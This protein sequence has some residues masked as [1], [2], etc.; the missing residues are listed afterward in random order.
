MSEV[1]PVYTDQRIR[2]IS[3]GGVSPGVI[4]DYSF[5][6]ETI[7]PILVG[8]FFANWS[9]HTATP[10]RR[11]RYLLDVPASMEPRIRE[12]NLNFPRQVR[13]GG[14]RVVYDWTTAE[15][16]KVESEPF[17]ADSNE[18]YMY[19]Q[20]SAPLQWADVAR[21]YHG[22]SAERYS[23]TPEIEAKV[24]EVVRDARTLD[25]S[26]RAVHRWIAQDIRY[27]SLSLGIGGYQPRIPAEVFSTQYGDC[28]DKATLFVAIAR[29]MGVRAHPVLLSS[30]GGV[31]RSLPSIRQF[32]HMIAAVERP[33]GG[34]TYLDLTAELIPYSLVSPAYQG[35]FGL[36]VHPDG[37]GE[38]ITFPQDPPSANRAVVVL[39]GEMDAD[40]V[41]RG[42]L[43]RTLSGGMQYGLRNSFSA[44]FSA[45]DRE[46]MARVAAGQV[47]E[48]AAGDS[49]RIFDGRDLNARVETQLWLR[50]G[51][52]ATRSGE[53]LIL[54][55]PVAN[56]STSQTLAELDAAPRPRRFPV[57]V[58]SVIGPVETHS[59]FRV[60]LPE[61]YRARLPQRVHAASEFGTYTAEYT[62]EGRELRVVR[63]ISG[64]R[65]VLPPERVESLSAWL[66]EMN[67][68]DV[69][70][71]VLEP[72]S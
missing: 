43:T 32:D 21:W 6:I 55:I 16:P 66:R 1:A 40:G 8:D 47:F 18:V 56:G 10:V 41:F 65:G 19:I 70:F 20:A 26:L 14:G 17:A 31:D 72:A 39:A 50:G 29:R 54:T 64:D 71:I 35:E 9:V 2:R 68:D 58:A 60:T 46:E 62:Q 36:V 22:L 7:D 34:Y 57:D 37:R 4:I 53:T 49:I 63:R 12:W 33:E 5:T 24:A 45:K 25:D 69:R 27:V 28:K 38:E 11:S 23:L 3:M 52:A 51:R 13:R 59:E 42:S 61:G 15:V 44:Q 67:R 48:G 30:N